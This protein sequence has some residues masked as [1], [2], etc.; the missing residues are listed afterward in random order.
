[1]I[2]YRPHCGGLDE[3][4][5]RVVNIS[6]IEELITHI[7]PFFGATPENVT[8]EPYGWDERIDWDTHLVCVDNNAIGY[9]DGKF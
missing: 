2:K 1:M 6:S 4:M 8:I 5:E 7:D 9:T 3:A